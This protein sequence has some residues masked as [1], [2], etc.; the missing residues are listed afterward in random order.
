MNSL[1]HGLAIPAVCCRVV[2]AQG[3]RHV[4]EQAA[5]LDR[6]FRVGKLGQLGSEQRRAEVLFLD[7]PHFLALR[8]FS[9]ARRRLRRG[10]G[11]SVPLGRT[12]KVFHLRIKMRKCQFRLR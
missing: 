11:T 1:S 9:R 10:R 8:R 5:N 2:C 3:P 4:G 7:V 12:A 6:G